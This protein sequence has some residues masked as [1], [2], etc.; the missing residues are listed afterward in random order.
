MRRRETDRHY[1]GD[2]AMVWVRPPQ[3]RFGLGDESVR[4]ANDALVGE[5]QVAVGRAVRRSVARLLR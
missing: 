2:W 5:R 4:G 3:Q 1:W